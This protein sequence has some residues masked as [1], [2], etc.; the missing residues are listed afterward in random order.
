MTT[1]RAL[2]VDRR[3]TKAER[4]EQQAQTL[5]DE[6][7]RE[8]IA[9]FPKIGDWLLVRYNV[10]NGHMMNREGVV[11]KADPA[12]RRL[13]VQFGK[14]RTCDTCHQKTYKEFDWIGFDQILERLDSPT[15]NVPR[16]ATKRG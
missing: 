2:P 3:L 7:E 1:T 11:K 5:R 10:F 12:R 14:W 6:V 13:M 15:Q 16:V 9:N 4:L 8:F